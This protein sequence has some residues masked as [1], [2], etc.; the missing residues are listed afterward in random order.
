MKKTL[1][2]IMK[3]YLNKLFHQVNISKVIR[4]LFVQNNFLYFL[5]DQSIANFV[6]IAFVKIMHKEDESIP[7]MKIKRR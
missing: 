6:E 4:V 7:I 5:I 1:K 2:F 3:I